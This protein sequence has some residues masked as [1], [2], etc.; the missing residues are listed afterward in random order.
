M[1]LISLILSS[2]RI[3]MQSQNCSLA[4][5]VL[6]GSFLS[7]LS[8]QNWALLSMIRIALKLARL[9]FTLFWR[10]PSISVRRKALNEFLAIGNIQILYYQSII[11]T[12]LLFFPLQ[13]S[14]K[15]TL[16]LKAQVGISKL[17]QEKQWNEKFIPGDRHSICCCDFDEKEVLNIV[18]SRQHELIS[19]LVIWKGSI[20]YQIN[21]HSCIKMQY[22][23]KTFKSTIASK[24][25]SGTSV[26]CFLSLV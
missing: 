16:K 12:F 7:F 20:H 25:K 11:C 14:W 5:S 22:Q 15:S 21:E 19:I 10:L 2:H 23:W 18:L 17:K 1:K 13:S 9:D 3:L 26:D 4:H 8:N 6:I 24:V